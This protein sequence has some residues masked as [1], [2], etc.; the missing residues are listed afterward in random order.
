MHYRTAN[1]LGALGIALADAQNEQ[2]SASSGLKPTDAAALNAI[3]LA[4]GCNISMVR[5]TLGITHPG[6]VRTVDRLVA[7]GL[8]GRRAG[9]DGRT[10][11]LHLTAE[12]EH[13]W[14]QQ[15]DAR[16]RWLDRTV[17]QLSSEERADVERVA[18]ALLSA[19][20]GDW[21]SSERICRLC[22]ERRCPQN[23]CP[24]TLAVKS[25]P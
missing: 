19:L 25:S 7:A 8:V 20:T 24:V 15:S 21:E 16:L 10:V 3:G 11:S 2:L 1:L 22:D 5:V 13:V 14:Q 6:T 12:G 9:V 18:S 23:R 4:P 17:A